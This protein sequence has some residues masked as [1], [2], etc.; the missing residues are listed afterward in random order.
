MTD[1]YIINQHA[2]GSAYI[3]DPPVTNTDKDFVVLAKPGYEQF[4]SDKGFTYSMSEQEYDSLGE[5][6]SWRKGSTN[7]IVTPAL[8]LRSKYD[9]IALFQCILYGLSV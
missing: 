4:L 8:N 5:F 9:R 2:T 7:L 1:T 3:C 6:T